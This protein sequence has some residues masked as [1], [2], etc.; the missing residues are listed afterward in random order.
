MVSCI[1]PVPVGMATWMSRMRLPSVSVR[2]RVMVWPGVK[3][4]GS[5]ATM[6]VS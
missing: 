6:P 2:R 1:E 3:P 4:L 5:P